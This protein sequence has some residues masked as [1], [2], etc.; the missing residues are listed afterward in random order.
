MP[1]SI[2]KARPQ[3]VFM[4]TVFERFSKKHKKVSPCI[5][6]KE[7]WK[8]IKKGPFWAVFPAFP[9][10]HFPRPFGARIPLLSPAYACYE[11]WSFGLKYLLNHT[12]LKNMMKKPSL[13]MNTQNH[14]N[15]YKR[16]W[17][18]SWFYDARKIGR[19]TSLNPGASQNRPSCI[20][21]YLEY[22]L[23]DMAYARDNKGFIILQIC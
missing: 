16:Q 18:I 4:K 12:F 11:W 5:Y 1:H 17:V 22:H 9:L 6:S 20:L 23:L 13:F 7:S 14:L 2:L 8:R 15:L 10:T 21:C 3:R 19:N